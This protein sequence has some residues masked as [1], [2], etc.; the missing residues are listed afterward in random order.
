MATKKA[1]PWGKAA[2]VDEVV[3]EQQAPGRGFATHVQLLETVD[4]K[5]LVRLAYSTSEQHSVRR[6]PVTM[7]TDDLGR[8]LEE[9]AEHPELASAFGLND[10]VKRGGARPR[11]PSGLGLRRRA[12]PG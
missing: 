12:S 3:V 1:T 2:L 5:R 4:G 6:G 9:L 7:T 8:L 11:R 10:V